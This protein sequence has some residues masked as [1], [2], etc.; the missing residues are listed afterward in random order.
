MNIFSLLG[1]KTAEAHVG[2]VIGHQELVNNL[3]S[4][5]HLFANTI[6][7][8]QNLSLI[9]GTIIAVLALWFGLRKIPKLM[10]WFKNIKHTATT[11]KEFVPWILRLSLGIAMLG[12]AGSQVLISPLMPYSGP[13]IAI[14]LI[15]GFSLLFGFLVT[16]AAIGVITLYIYTLTQDQYFIGNFEVLGAALALIAFGSGRPGFDDL[17]GIPELKFNTLLPHV[18]EVIRVA[19][20]TAMT[21]LAL[22]E[23]IFNPHISQLVVEKFSL[24]SFIPVNANMW[25]VSTGIIE[26]IIGLAFLFNFKVRTISIITFFVLIMTFFAFREEVYAHV[27]LFGMLSVLFI[28]GDK[29]GYKA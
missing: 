23:K 28:I 26:L 24:T 14:E 13:L 12:A 3:G 4:D 2:Y 10:E 22:F 1:I 20:G 17:V 25:V 16:P 11:Y 29:E 8:Q 7:T 6:F 27:T 21:Y 19:L 18:G 9:I 15:L 5:P